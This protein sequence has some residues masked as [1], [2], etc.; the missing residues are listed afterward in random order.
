M[1][2]TKAASV[3]AVTRKPKIVSLYPQYERLCWQL[4]AGIQ[5]LPL[6]VHVPI[7][8][9]LIVNSTVVVAL[10]VFKSVEIDVTEQGDTVQTR[11]DSEYA[12]GEAET[13]KTK[14]AL[15]FPITAS[16]SLFGL[17]LVF[18]YIN[19]DLIK[20]LL[21][22]YFSY[23]GMY[24]LGLF[25]AEKFLERDESLREISYEKQTSLKIPYLMEEPLK[26]T[27]R[28]ADNYG[29]AISFVLATAYCLT[30]H[31]LLNN[32][33]G[34]TFA[35]GAIRLIKLTDIKIGLIMLWGLFFY[36]IFWVF[37]TD[38]MVTV[39]K[40]MDGPILLK[41]PLNLAE[42]KFSMLGLGDMIVPGA[43]IS[44][45]LKFDVDSYLKAFPKCKLEQI[46][47]PFF[48]YNLIFYLLGIVITYVFM[49]W[50]NHAQPALLYL[51]PA[52]T[53]GLLIPAVQRGGYQEMIDYKIAESE[54]PKDE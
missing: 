2:G 15:M 11:Y 41:F 53:I 22:I 12:S 40:S 26:I 44:L 7:G 35:I 39:A 31:W 43:F 14:D 46:R 21:K 10:G 27:M 29:F 13:V 51:V 6:F 34:V 1:D 17:Y 16:I 54:P 25:F 50:F 28:K 19:K 5:L 38:V 8:A 37:K 24:V 52:A 3:E 47:T 18:T 42:N 49:Q 30:S 23:L 45:L 9:Q 20:G 4:L 48:W 32:L 33:F 36:D